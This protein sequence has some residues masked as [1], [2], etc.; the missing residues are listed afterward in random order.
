MR[1]SIH[2]HPLP[3]PPPSTFFM[4][5]PQFSRGPNANNSFA[6]PEFRSRRTGTLAT[7]ANMGIY[8][9]TLIIFCSN[10]SNSLSQCIY[11]I[12]ETFSSNTSLLRTG[13]GLY[14][15]PGARPSAATV[16]RPVDE[17]KASEASCTIHV[18]LSATW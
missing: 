1:A 6:R 7:Q 17:L 18:S 15:M 12:S 9:L 5:S 3:H 4:L 11:A 10:S 14:P 16:S 2:F 13:L 8:S